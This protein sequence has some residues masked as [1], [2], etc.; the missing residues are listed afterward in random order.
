MFELFV[1]IDCGAYFAPSEIGSV[2]LEH[3]VVI[4]H[5]DRR[6][7]EFEQDILQE[8]NKEAF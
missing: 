3:D 6:R 2:I 7:S 4:F 5:S 1:F 8:E